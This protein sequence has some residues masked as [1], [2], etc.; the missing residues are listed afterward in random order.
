MSESMDEE[1]FHG[2]GYFQRPAL[3]HDSD[4]ALSIVKDEQFAPALPITEFRADDEAVALAND[5]V[6]GL[7]SSARTPSV[8]S[9]W[10]AVSRPD[11]LVSK[12]ADR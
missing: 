11:T 10:P 2:R 7:S 1:F 3:V 8:R 4:P 12:V 6:Y 9:A 5:S